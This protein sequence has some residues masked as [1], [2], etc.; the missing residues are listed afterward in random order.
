VSE[1]SWED[2][3]GILVEGHLT[4]RQAAEHAAAAGA[5]SLLLTHFWPT[6]NRERARELAAAAFDGE[7]VVADEGLTIPVGA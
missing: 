2:E 1:A 7:V 5:G 4:A 3:D 6:V